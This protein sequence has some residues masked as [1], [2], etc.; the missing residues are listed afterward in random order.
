MLS[1]QPSVLKGHLRRGLE[2]TVRAGG[3][4]EMLRDAVFWTWRACCTRELPV[5]FVTCKRPAE[6]E[7]S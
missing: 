5:A 2:K 1:A 7:A 4:R 6:D 3:C